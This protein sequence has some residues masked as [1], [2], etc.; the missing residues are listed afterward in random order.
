MNFNE[1]FKNTKLNYNISYFDFCYVVSKILDI[2]KNDII[3]LDTINS[4]DAQ[5]IINV[6]DEYKNGKP[7]NKIFC[8][9]NF[10]GLDFFINENFLSPRCDTEILVEKAIELINDKPSKVLDLCCGSGCI[11]ITVKKFC[12]NAY[13]LLSD[14][15]L[16]ALEVSKINDKKFETQV[17]FCH[18]D[19]FNSIPK[20][21]FDFILSNPP[22]IKNTDKDKLDKEVLLY[23]P[24][25]ALFGGDD[26]L[27]FYNEILKNADKFLVENG[28]ILFEIGYDICNDVINLAKK[29]GYVSTIFKDYSGINRVLMLC[30]G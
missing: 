18:S 26:G 21:K 4:L 28:R 12:K 22:Y 9:K 8:E 23:D 16:K 14:I 29:Y 5:K 10:F 13:V 7:L 1:F 20:Q 27:Y 24:H 6:L 3:K 2:D 15:S 17:D 25:I 19:L 30:K 11:G